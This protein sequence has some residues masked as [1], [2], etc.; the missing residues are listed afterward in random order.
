MKLRKYSVICKKQVHFDVILL[1]YSVNTI[2]EIIQKL[3]DI[4]SQNDLFMDYYEQK[5]K[6]TKNHD[7]IL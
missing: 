1:C 6:M 5:L 3:M 2:Y 4:P 7:L